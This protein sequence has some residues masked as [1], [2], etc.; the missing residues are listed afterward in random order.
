MNL[1]MIVRNPDIYLKNQGK[2]RAQTGYSIELRV[3]R[4]RPAAE[5]RTFNNHGRTFPGSPLQ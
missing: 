2:S 3:D 1:G 4:G 5:I